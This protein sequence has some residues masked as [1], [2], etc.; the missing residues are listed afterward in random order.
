[1]YVNKCIP[2]KKYFDKTMQ[3]EKFEHTFQ[4]KST[5]RMSVLR[6]GGV[7]RSE[8]GIRVHGGENAQAELWTNMTSQRILLIGWWLK[9]DGIEEEE[10]NRN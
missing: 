8:K 4:A 1:M 6:F 3:F 2:D 7:S 5:V 10:V 9:Q